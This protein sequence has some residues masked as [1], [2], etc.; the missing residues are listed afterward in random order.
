M[1]CP[2][3]EVLEKLRKE[4]ALARQAAVD[5]QAEAER[6]REALTQRLAQLHQEAQRTVSL[7]DAR[8]LLQLGDQVVVPRLGY[9]RPGRVVKLDPRKKTAKV[10][11]GHVTWDVSIDELMPQ[12]PRTPG[13]GLALVRGL[14]RVKAATRTGRLRR[15]A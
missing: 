10:A 8:A 1:G 14:H 4:A 2:D 12:T 3:W 5:A 15:P 11:I 7:A 6:T 9:D 13:A